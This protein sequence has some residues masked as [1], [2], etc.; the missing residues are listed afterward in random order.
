MT[1][2]ITS[3]L[4]LSFIVS[5]ALLLGAGNCGGGDDDSSGGDGGGS[6]DPCAVAGACGGGSGGSSGTGGVTGGGDIDIV[7]DG[8][9]DSAWVAFEHDVVQRVNALRAQGGT[10]GTG[11]SARTFPASGALRIDSRLV[12]AARGHADDMAA[13]NYFSHDSLDGRSPFD[14]MIDAGYT[15][16]AAAEN[17]AAGQATPAAVVEGWRLSPGHCV[18]MYEPSLN[19]IGVGYTFE[20]GDQYRHYWV[21]NLGQR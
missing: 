9:R 15:G 14:R 18:N 3:A 11:A 19:E 1:H 10:C 8:L 12:D 6:V 16:F 7:D 4:R 2:A 13:R 20:A 17:I 5:G 21:Q